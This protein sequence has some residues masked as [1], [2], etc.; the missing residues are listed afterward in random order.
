M[1]KDC[2]FDNTLLIHPNKEFMNGKVYQFAIAAIK[3]W[4]L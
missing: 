2:D 1:L 4:D 3:K